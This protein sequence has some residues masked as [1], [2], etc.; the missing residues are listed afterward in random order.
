MSMAHPFLY[1]APRYH[2]NREPNIAA[3]TRDPEANAQLRIALHGQGYGF[4]Q[5][6][7]N[8]PPKQRNF[9]LLPPS[10]QRHVVIPFATNDDVLFCTTRPP[11]S[12]YQHNDKKKVEPSNTTLEHLIFEHY[13]RYFERCSRSWIEFTAQAAACLPENKKNRASMTFAQS[14]CLYTSLGALGEKRVLP[15]S[16]RGR[17][18]AFLL[19]VDELWPGGPG[20]KA[21]W[22]L[23]AVATVVWCWLL[24]ERYSALLDHRGL[25]VVEM[26][27]KDV[28]AQAAT[29]SWSRDWDVTPLMETC[30]ELPAR[31]AKSRILMSE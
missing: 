27:P 16:L 12:D 6:I 2:A 7:L 15:G 31:P 17:T 23:N 26:V 24:R 1:A 21:A 9:R 4:G 3:D 20:L 28:P 8:F 19:S 13:F 10:E 29:Y 25:T 22:G 30:V 14:G 5:S 11:L 18:A